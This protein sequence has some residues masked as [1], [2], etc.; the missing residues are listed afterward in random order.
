MYCVYIHIV[1]NNK[2]YVGATMNDPKIRWGNGKNYSRNKQF[3]NDIMNYGW[4]NITHI[5]PYNHL[6]KE[7][8]KEK[9]KELIS[10]FNSNNFQY[11]YNKSRGGE[12]RESPSLE[13]R[14]KQSASLQNKK[15]KEV[16]I[17]KPKEVV[18]RKGKSII[19][20]ETQK[21]FPR[22]KDASE[23]YEIC[24]ETIRKCCH[25]KRFTAGGYHWQFYEESGYK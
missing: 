19:C 16:F 10:F 17:H 18:H 5:V 23:Y 6:T 2:I 14:I 9:E 24:D 1:P 8:A 15:A 20:I 13:T 21:I 7:E 3:Y 12:I 11:G 22:I 4:S 25:K